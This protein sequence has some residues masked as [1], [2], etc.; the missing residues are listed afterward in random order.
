MV[1][2][3]GADRYATSALVAE[4]AFAVAPTIILA[5]GGTY[6]DALA[7]SFLAGNMAAP[8]LLTTA[9]LPLS[10][11]TVG[12]LVTLQT[13]NVILLGGLSAISAAEQTTLAQTYNV[14]R[15]SG[16]TRYD[17]M[18]AIDTNPGTTV[19]VF[20]GLRTAFL[21]T[22]TDFPDALGAG[23]ISYAKKFPIILTAGAALSPQAAATLTALGIQ[24][25]IILGGTAA[26]TSGVEVAVNAMGIGTLV[27]FAGADRV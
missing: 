14:T 25:V 2:V 17:T 16:A 8:V 13:R 26:I 27:R 23:P 22:G 21:A 5:T 10:P 4:R 11:S 7:A 19:G 24:Q 1:R 20:N 15:I 6:P 18:A 12:A 9:D 3:A